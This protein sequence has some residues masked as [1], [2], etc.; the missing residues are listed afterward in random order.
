MASFLEHSWMKNKGNSSEESNTILLQALDG[1]TKSETKLSA[2]FIMLE[3]GS[4]EEKLQAMR[5]VKLVALQGHDQ[6]TENAVDDSEEDEVYLAQ[7]DSSD[8]SELLQ[9][10]S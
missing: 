9:P 4:P 1:G 5:E 6:T 8:D 2:L 7:D 3:F 10:L